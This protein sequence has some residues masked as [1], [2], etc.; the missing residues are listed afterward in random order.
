MAASKNRKT[1]AALYIFFI[2]A[3]LRAFEKSSKKY[4]AVSANNQTEITNE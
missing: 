4:A 1:K 3:F 2:T